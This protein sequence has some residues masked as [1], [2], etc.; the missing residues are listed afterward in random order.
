M[1]KQQLT[2]PIDHWSYSSLSSFLGN[3]AEFRRKYIMKIKDTPNRPSSIVGSA[4]HKA[5]EAYYNQGLSQDEAIAVGLEYMA[6]IR[7][8]NIDFGKTGTREQMQNTYGQA[9]RFYFEEEPHFHE[10]LGVEVGETFEAK[11]IFTGEPLPLPLTAYL[12]VIERNKLGR[13]EVTDHKFV[14][15]YEPIDKQLMASY[16]KFIQAMFYFHYVVAKYGE[17]PEC[18][19]Y[20]EIK[21]SRNRDGSPQLQPYTFYYNDENRNTYF[22][23]FYKLLD[24]ATYNLGLPIKYLPN[25][26]DMFDGQYS[27]ELFVNGIDSIEAP[28]AVKH[29]QEMTKFVDKNYIPSALD[30]VENQNLTPE[31]RIRAKMQEFNIAVDMRDTYVGPSITKYTLKPQRGIPMKK[32]AALRDD[33]SLALKA[34][35]V[36]IEAPVPGTDVVGIEVPSIERKRIDMADNFLKPGTLQ[37]PVGVNVYNETIYKDLAEAPHLLIAGSTGAGKSVMINVLIEALTKQ[38][39][40]DRLQMV[41]I[42]PKQVEL[43]FFDDLPHLYRDVVTDVSSAQKVLTELVDE[44]ERRYEVLK[45]A[46]VRKIDDYKGSMPRIVV[47]IDEFADLMMMA[48]NKQASFTASLPGII[49]QMSEAA[50]AEMFKDLIF[51]EKQLRSLARKAKTDPLAE[52]TLV[53]HRT[54]YKQLA[55]R[56]M[57]ETASD[58]PPAEESIIRIAQKARAVG[59]HL[60][61]ATQRPSAEVVTGLLK[62]NI[63]TK[64]CF[65]TTSRVNSQIVLDESGAEELTRKGD[66]LYSDPS[67]SGL[68]RL[69]GLYA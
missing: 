9:I 24:G 20:N 10:I 30:K 64:I 19:H 68:Q 3:P 40:K 65:A 63:P 6:G 22:A 18:I 34:S 55:E 33:M 23:A 51:D 26:N 45:Y 56:I 48:D 5:L 62:A 59:I 25:P 11:N 52:A 15:S 14:G 28:V 61:L 50:D 13:I 12:D 31:E 1:T 35:S 60:V 36:R 8:A 27:F 7:D 4:A 44:M 46:G 54:A 43:T 53:A 37:F 41:L 66:M 39:D 69:Q 2:L 67:F 17:E 16:K 58:L 42:D 47:I 29:K 49:H 38:L 32:I 21:T 57:A